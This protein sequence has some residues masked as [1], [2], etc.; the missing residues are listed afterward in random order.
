MLVLTFLVFAVI[1]RDLISGNF[2]HFTSESY[3]SPKTCSHLLDELPPFNFLCSSSKWTLP[4]LNGRCALLHWT[5]LALNRPCPGLLSDDAIP[6]TIYI[7]KMW[8]KKSLLLIQIKTLSTG[9]KR[10]TMNKQCTKDVSARRVSCP[11]E[12]KDREPEGSCDHVMP[13]PFFSHPPYLPL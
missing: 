12:R 7:W 6:L 5:L 10:D 1:Q 8:D 9:P 2:S 4:S 11:R 13:A 3:W